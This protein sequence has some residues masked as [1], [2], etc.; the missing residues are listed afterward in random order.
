ML[1]LD[2]S[3]AGNIIASN[4]D[5]KMLVTPGAYNRFFAANQNSSE[6]GASTRTS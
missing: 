3:E 6:D 4:P 1:C 2:I 5:M